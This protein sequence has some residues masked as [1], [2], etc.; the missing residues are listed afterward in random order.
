MYK[1]VDIPT[2]Q[3][4]QAAIG[5]IVLNPQKQA[6]VIQ[7]ITRDRMDGTGAVWDV[8]DASV[9]MYKGED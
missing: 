2:T 4:Y 9:E 5:Y 7:D 1:D 6:R 3:K 8:H